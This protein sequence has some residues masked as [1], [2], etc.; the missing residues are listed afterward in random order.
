MQKEKEVF[1]VSLKADKSW[2][3]QPR[4]V[5]WSV[6]ELRNQR[7]VCFSYVTYTM[8]EMKTNTKKLHSDGCHSLLFKKACQLFM[9]E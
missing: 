8:G 3:I 9:P 2:R 6:D 4:F 1:M 5:E 7:T